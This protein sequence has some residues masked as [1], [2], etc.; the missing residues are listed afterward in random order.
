MG[1]EVYETSA[2]A[3]EIFD[4]AD[5]A[6][7]FSISKICFEGPEEELLRTEVQQ[8]AI[9]T[10][11]IALLRA[12]EEQGSIDPSFVAGHSLGGYTALVA[13]GALDFV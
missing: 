2:A 6:L 7:G 13:S 8:P 1:R 10:T 11:G 12:L 9:L 5:D 4:A 3:R